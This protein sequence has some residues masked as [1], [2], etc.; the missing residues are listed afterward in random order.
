MSEIVP[1]VPRSGWVK[2][3]SMMYMSEEDFGA[4]GMNGAVLELV[5]RV[6]VGPSTKIPRNGS[7]QS[8]QQGKNDSR[9]DEFCGWTVPNT[10]HQSVDS[11]WLEPRLLNDSQLAIFT[12]S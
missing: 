11:S 12:P 3:V 5:L 4:L 6:L 7:F 8:R 9:E 1:Y 10:G 2:L